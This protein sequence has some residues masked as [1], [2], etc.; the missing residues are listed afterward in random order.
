MRNETISDS[1]ETDLSLAFPS[2]VLDH[3]L[4]HANNDNLLID[5]HCYFPGPI[6][7]SRATQLALIRYFRT[8]VFFSYFSW[9][10]Q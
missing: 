1:L 8:R 2:T 10:L 3:T 4:I 7:S 6:L 9:S 5:D